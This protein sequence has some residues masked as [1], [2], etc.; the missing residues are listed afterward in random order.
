MLDEEGPHDFM[1]TRLMASLEAL[2]S[3]KHNK[4]Y[5]LSHRDRA[6]MEA[7]LGISLFL[8]LSF[9]FL[10]RSLFLVLFLFLF[11][12]LFLS[13][14]IIS[15]YQEVSLLDW[16]AKMVNISENMEPIRNGRTCATS[17]TRIGTRA[18]FLSWTLGPLTHPDL[19]LKPKVLP[20]CTLLALT[21]T[22]SHNMLHLLTLFLSPFLLFILDG[23]TNTCQMT[24]QD[25]R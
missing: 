13:F 3:K 25:L 10:F 4:V 21:H 17:W 14:L 7:R 15:N 22:P 9:F 18:S 20:S 6:Y 2:C 11:P 19:P 16:H 24:L 8:A 12:S 23:I 5:I 1:T